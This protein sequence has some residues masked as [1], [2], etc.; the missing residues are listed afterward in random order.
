MLRGRTLGNYNAEV[1]RDLSTTSGELK[2][3]NTVTLSTATEAKGWEEAG[4]VHVNNYDSVDY[5]RYCVMCVKPCSEKASNM[6]DKNGEVSS[7]SESVS[8]NTGDMYYLNNSNSQRVTE[9]TA[10][11]NVEVLVLDTYSEL[12][13]RHSFANAKYEA[14][15]VMHEISNSVLGGNSSIA[16]TIKNTKGDTLLVDEQG[17]LYCDR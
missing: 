11:D 9:L 8:L 4:Y 15:R 16:G 1:L 6:A 14:N 2:R 12:P 5:P 13:E 10:S 7:S 3:G 17:R